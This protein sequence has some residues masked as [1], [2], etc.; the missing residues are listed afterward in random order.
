MRLGYLLLLVCGL[1]LAEPKPVGPFAPNTGGTVVVAA[2]TTSG[3]TTVALVGNGAQVTISSLPTSG[4]TAY[5]EMGTST[6][7]AAVATGFPVFPGVVM[8]VARSS[9]V[10]HVACITSASTATIYYTTGEGS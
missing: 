2:T 8:T 10:T 6:V 9:G 7:T 5:C 4:A 3:S 1:A